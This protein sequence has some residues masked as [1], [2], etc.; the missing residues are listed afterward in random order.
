MN[1]AI[2][3]PA[4]AGTFYPDD[5]TLLREM[6]ERMLNAAKVSSELPPKAVVAPHAG[7]IYSGPF[8]AYAFKTLL[9]LFG[10]EP[11]V[12]LLGPAHFVAFNGVST[13][14]FTAWETPL[15]IV[16]V[17]V[18]R[19]REVLN[20][21]YPFTDVSEPLIPEHSLEVELPFLQVVLGSFRIVPLAFGIVNPI[22]VAQK[23]LGVLRE[24]D[25]IVVSTDLSHYYPD[26]VARKL[27]AET[28]KIALRNDAEA[29]ME[30]EACGRYAWATLAAIAREMGWTPT[31]LAYGTSADTAGD[32]DS[33]VGYA[34]L[35]Y[36]ALTL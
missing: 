7:Y 23:L 19:V 29:L 3:K 6:V 9:P 26:P 16:P 28:L 34:A 5:P 17:A 33:V 11:T 25:I 2:R 22:G 10:A 8:A 32:P 31:L 35:R 13:G 30:R 21:G 27:D 1:D 15:G 12:F 24:G 36:D 14:R 20:L 4:V 18:D